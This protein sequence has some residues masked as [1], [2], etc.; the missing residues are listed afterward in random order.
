MAETSSE[1]PPEVV[2]LRARLKFRPANAIRDALMKESA[3]FPFL[4]SWALARLLAWALFDQHE[5]QRIPEEE[6]EDRAAHRPFKP[7]YAYKAGQ[8][9]LWYH[10]DYFSRTYETSSYFRRMTVD[11]AVVALEMYCE[12]AHIKKDVSHSGKTLSSLHNDKSRRRDLLFVYHI[13]DF[14]VRATLSGRK[15]VCKVK[16]ARFFVEKLEPMGEQLSASRIEKTW[17]LYR[18]A[19]PYIYAF[20][21]K[22]YGTYSS[23]GAFAEAKTITEEEDWFSCVAQLA[24]NSTL[25]ECL[26]HAAFAADV[27]EKTGTRDVRIKDFKSL[28]RVRPLLREFNA[29]EELIFESYDDTGP[30]E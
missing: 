7:R 9:Y 15:D 6:R 10:L 19:A 25:E 17:N 1:I 20:Y 3:E 30:L 5:S 18:T 16:I 8:L 28:S 23:E 24:T 21:P 14:L 22:L 12:T 27:L 13:M 2:E 26:G 29:N 11:E 4:A